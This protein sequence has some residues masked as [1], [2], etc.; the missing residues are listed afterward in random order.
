MLATK[1]IATGVTHLTDARYFAAWEVDVVGFDLSENGI[2]WPAFQAMREWIEGP[3]IAV[4]VS[5]GA[6]AGAVV[7]EVKSHAVSTILLPAAA[8]STYGPD[9]PGTDLRIITIQPVAGYQS[10]GDVRD[11]LRESPA[12]ATILDFESGGITWG[13]LLGGH[14]FGTRELTDLLKDREV[15]LQIDLAG[16]DPK[17]IAAEFPIAGFAVRGSGEEKV[18]YKS[19]DDLDPLFEGLEVFD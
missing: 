1:V 4:E 12:S 17:A 15:Y 18:G 16:T 5:E 11:T 19:F 10:A 2:D 7:G 14:P 9:L 8:Y 3:E 6:D 13:D